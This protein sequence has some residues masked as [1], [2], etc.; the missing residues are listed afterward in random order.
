VEIDTHNLPLFDLFMSLREKGL[1]LGIDE[2]HL[3]L[4]AL[5]AGFG[6]ADRTALERLCRTLWVK[7]L[8]EEHLFDYHFQRMIARLPMAQSLGPV[9][10]SPY[11]PQHK[12]DRSAD[13][14]EQQVEDA[15]RHDTDIG[16]Q[17]MPSEPQE[18]DS[19]EP[20]DNDDT[21]PPT[22]DIAPMASRPPAVEINSAGSLINRIKEL[23][24][25]AQVARSERKHRPTDEYFP[26]SRRQLKQSWRYL[27]CMV[28]VGPPIELDIEST[29]EQI[30]RHGSLIEPVLKPRQINRTEVLLLLDNNGS[31]V[32]FHI[33]SRRLIET[34]LRGGRLGKTV[35]HYFHNCP[36]EQLHQDTLDHPRYK[37]IVVLIFSDAGAARGNYSPERVDSTAQWF[38]ALRRRARYVAW[39][40]PMPHQRWRGT[41]A[42]AIARFVPMFTID[43]SGIDNAI[44]VLRGHAVRL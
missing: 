10:A 8:D 18:S 11:K 19:K 17:P 9:V 37:R 41:T 5:E 26:I 24:L 25:A 42:E 12:P 4:R 2:Y 34:A 43:R 32:P 35:I 14:A 33:L 27:R 40:N 31:M 36:S 3:A 44:S 21:L 39:I 1:A 23:S 13:L 30:G 6:V 38:T 20:L 22:G 29:I 7:S 16:P 15:S 28:R